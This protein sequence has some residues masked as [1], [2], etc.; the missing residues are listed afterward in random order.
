MDAKIYDNGSVNFY[1]NCTDLWQRCL[2]FGH[3]Y[4]VSINE[5]YILPIYERYITRFFGKFR[6]RYLVPSRSFPLEWQSRSLLVSEQYLI[7]QKKQ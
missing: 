5:I 1:L 7:R 4:Y 6:S 2:Q 3:P